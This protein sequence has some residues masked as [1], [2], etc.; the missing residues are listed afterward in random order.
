MAGFVL[1][2]LII[3]IIIGGVIGYVVVTYNSLVG[4]R[5]KVNDQW[6]DRYRT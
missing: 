5:N 6:T 3:V 2:P 4:L 1:I